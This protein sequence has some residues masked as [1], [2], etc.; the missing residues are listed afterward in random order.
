MNYRE[1]K[2]DREYC[3]E[4]GRGRYVSTKIFISILAEPRVHERGMTKERKGR[5]TRGRT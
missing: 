5:N 2:C 1:E 4:R 3:D